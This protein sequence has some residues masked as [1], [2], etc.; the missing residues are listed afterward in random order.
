MFAPCLSVLVLMNTVESPVGSN[1]IRGNEHITLFRSADAH[2]LCESASRQRHAGVYTARILHLCAHAH[3]STLLIHEE[4]DSK[5]ILELYCDTNR[6][7]DLKF[8]MCQAK[9]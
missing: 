4:A 5:E 7:S 3:T 8:R 6:Q 2:R 1:D 9:G